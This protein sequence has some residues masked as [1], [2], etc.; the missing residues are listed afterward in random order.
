MGE[1]ISFRAEHVEIYCEAV[2]VK[3]FLSVSVNI[4]KCASVAQRLDWKKVSITVVSQF[5]CKHVQLEQRR[6]I[7]EALFNFMTPAFPLAPFLVEQCDHLEMLSV[8]RFQEMFLTH[9]IFFYTT[10]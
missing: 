6:A 3:D 7:S 5:D 4:R 8:P 10:P 1:N 9:G 2:T